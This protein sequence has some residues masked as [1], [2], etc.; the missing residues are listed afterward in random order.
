MPMEIISE[1]DGLPGWKLNKICP[2][3]VIPKAPNIREPLLST[4]QPSNSL[5]PVV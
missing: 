5:C 1:L 4:K 3:V 2:D